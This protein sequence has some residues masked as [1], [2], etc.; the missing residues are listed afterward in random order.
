MNLT[1]DYPLF[2]SVEVMTYTTSQLIEFLD[3]ELKASW[4]G[5]RIVLSSQN[6]LDNPIIAKA[7]GTEKLS[8]VFAYR[9]FRAQIHQYQKQHQV[10]GLIWRECSF[11]GVCVRFPEIHNQLVAVPGDKESLIRAKESVLSFWYRTT[12]N[13]QFWLSGNEP[14][15]IT[16]QTLAQLTQK[17]EWAEVDVAVQEL[18]LGLCWGNPQEYRYQWAKPDSGCERIIAA[19]NQPSCLKF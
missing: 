15:P 2:S 9:D 7:L 6:R 18:Y 5:E 12:E 4:R 3:Q 8:K 10:S 1:A 14:Q 17:A 13:F 19:H 11:E 16:K